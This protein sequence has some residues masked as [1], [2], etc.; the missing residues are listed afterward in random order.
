M[1]FTGLNLDLLEQTMKAREYFKKLAG[2]VDESHQAR[3]YLN[4]SDLDR[5]GLSATERVIYWGNFH[6]SNA[7]IKWNKWPKVRINPKHYDA[8]NKYYNKKRNGKKRTF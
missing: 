8:L 4:R 6:S 1:I 3:K 5:L 7:G 2:E